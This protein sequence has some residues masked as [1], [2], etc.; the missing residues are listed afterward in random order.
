MKV[1]Q[2]EMDLV[3]IYLQEKIKNTSSEICSNVE[4]TRIGHRLKQHITNPP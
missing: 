2:T 3:V 4:C 1:K